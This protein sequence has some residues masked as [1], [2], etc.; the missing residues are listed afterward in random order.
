MTH[1]TPEAPQSPETVIGS[2]DAQIVGGT[3][4]NVNV[5]LGEIVPASQIIGDFDMEFD[6]RL[7]ELGVAKRHGVPYGLA[8]AIRGVSSRQPTFDEETEAE[9]QAGLDAIR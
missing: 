3:R 1:K 5:V 2:S 8:A 4:G 6:P 9:F 7:I